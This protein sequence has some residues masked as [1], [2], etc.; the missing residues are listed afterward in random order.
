MQTNS[1]QVRSD[2]MALRTFSATLGEEDVEV[3]TLVVH[4]EPWFKGVDVA[5]ALGYTAP[6]KAVRTHVV[7]EDK[8]ELQNLGGTVSVPLT[9]PN[10]GA[11]VY[12][13]ESG[14]YS[15]IFRSKKLE[16]KLFKRWITT[17]V[18]PSI[19]RTGSYS[20]QPTLEEDCDEPL[21]TIEPNAVTEAQQ[22]DAR[23]ARLDAL[24]ASHTLATQ[25]GMSL[26]EAHMRAIKDVL[27]EV[28]LPVGRR[29]GDMIDAAEILERKGHTHT[30]IHR[31]AS[32]FGR[33][34]KT[35]WERT[36]LEAPATNLEQFGSGENNVRM[37]HARDDALF[38]DVVYE[39]FQKRE[40]YQRTCLGRENVRTQ[41]TQSVQDALQN[42]RG[43]ASSA[44][45]EPNPEL[46]PAGRKRPR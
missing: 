16:A 19:R 36:H 37:Y 13:S 28:I 43:F 39:A 20:A 35:A 8:Q 21:P 31:I 14:L 22:W 27:N 11:C 25:V 38:V 6:A 34:L 7:D 10:Q 4:G 44:K 46:R 9:N 17:Q 45:A 18:L 33:A 26:G 3:D 2:A 30:Q 41:L 15:L 5:A 29:Q 23:R 42:T 12:I 24:A 1:P 40:L 32:E